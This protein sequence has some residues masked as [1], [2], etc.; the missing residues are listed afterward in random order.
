MDMRVEFTTSIKDYNFP[1][2]SG[3]MMTAVKESMI[4]AVLYERINIF[5][6][7]K[8]HDIIENQSYCSLF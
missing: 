8:A 3:K 1:E 4:N 2:L 5:K 6:Q 7:A